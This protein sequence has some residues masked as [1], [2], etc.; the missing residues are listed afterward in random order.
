MWGFTSSRQAIYEHD[1]LLVSPP[2]QCLTIA[3]ASYR[4]PGVGKLSKL[5]YSTLGHIDDKI[6]ERFAYRCIIALLVHIP[7]VATFALPCLASP[8]LASS[9]VRQGLIKTMLGV[10]RGRNGGAPTE[11]ASDKV[12]EGS[13]IPMT[14]CRQDQQDSSAESRLVSGTD[15]STG[16]TRLNVNNIDQGSV[17]NAAVC[18]MWCAIAIGALVQGQPPERVSRAS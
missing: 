8:C 15:C 3:R 12:A 1:N 13:D 7:F 9:N 4:V 11:S 6:V 2:T 17:K 16:D 18:E 14:I 5:R 10:R